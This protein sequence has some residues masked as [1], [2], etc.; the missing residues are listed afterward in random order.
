MEETLRPGG[1]ARHDAAAG[2]EGVRPVRL[3]H[4]HR[5]WH[6]TLLAGN[7]HAPTRERYS[8]AGDDVPRA[9]WQAG[10]DRRRDRHPPAASGGDPTGAAPRPAVVRHGSTGSRGGSPDKPAGIPTHH[11]RQQDGRGQ[12]DLPA[13]GGHQRRERRE[14]G[15]DQRAEARRRGARKC[16]LRVMVPEESEAAFVVLLIDGTGRGD[17]RPPLPLRSARRAAASRRAHPGGRGTAAR[18]CHSPAPACASAF[19]SKPARA[20]E[21][22]TGCQRRQDGGPGPASTETGAGHPPTVCLIA[23]GQPDVNRALGVSGGGYKEA[24]SS[25]L[26]PRA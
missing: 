23:A 6:P 15:R 17:E 24:R 7:R 16:T 13:G 14:D 1:G 26:R 5:K 4:A 2:A 25:C 18:R 10:P 12:P 19:R 9:G 8:R 22:P 21:D 11:D 3:R 20:T